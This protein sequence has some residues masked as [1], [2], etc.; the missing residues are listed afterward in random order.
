M[1]AGIIGFPS[2]HK[3]EFM[4]THTERVKAVLEGK[5]LD[6]PPF[7]AWGPHLNLEDR[8]TGDFTKAVIAY[9]NQH[10]FDIL[11]VMQNGL[12]PT[13]DFGQIIDEPK[14]SDDAGFRLTRVPAFRSLDDWKNATVKDVHKGAFG[15][16][17][18]SIKVLCQYY[19]ESL[20]V[21]PTIFGPSRMLSQLCGLGPKTDLYPGPFF[22][23]EDILSFAEDHRREYDHVMEILS[24]QTIDLMNAYI[25][26]G[27]AGFFY[28]TSGERKGTCTDDQY[29]KLIRPYEE[30]VL[31]AVYDKTWFT[32]LH[33]CG[34]EVV[35]MEQMVT[36]PVHAI[37][38]E[39]QAPANPSIADV[40]KMTDKVLMGGIDRNSDFYGASRA[41]V[42]SVLKSKVD[43]AI[44]EGGS[45]LV[46]ACGCE[47]NRET[48]HRFVVWH[49]V[50]DE[51]VKK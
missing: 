15:R 51:L 2:L 38:W 21:L 25:E 31:K 22:C 47:C 11:K 24:Q 3:K 28:C 41:K 35:R 13:E 50:M 26:V 16:E 42:K 48:N 43:E 23:T 1:Q 45:K 7:I 46:L 12:Y 9:Q 18:E 10:D 36:L 8:H 40:R 39:D 27:A 17:V 49:E 6:R 19:G 14:N 34:M 32:M 33:V 30:A 5:V 4:M 44:K 37:N 20:P 29:A